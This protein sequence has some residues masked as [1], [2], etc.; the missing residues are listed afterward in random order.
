[1]YKHFQSCLTSINNGLINRCRN[2]RQGLDYI[3]S[4]TCRHLRCLFAARIANCCT[5]YNEWHVNF[6]IQDEPAIRRRVRYSETRTRTGFN[7]IGSCC[8]PRSR[9]TINTSAHWLASAPA[10]RPSPDN[11][12]ATRTASI[13]GKYSNKNRTLPRWC[14][15]R[16]FFEFVEKLNSIAT[17]SVA[18]TTL[19][20]TLWLT[21]AALTLL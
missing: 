10:S 14:R 18:V 21:L 20:A 15:Q 19:L 4:G 6:I 17:L 16:C 13:K 2:A 3:P 9:T 12:D 7:A 8:G 11:T 1:M 5:R